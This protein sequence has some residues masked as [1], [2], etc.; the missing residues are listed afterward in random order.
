M[1]FR[2]RL[3]IGRACWPSL[4]SQ[5]CSPAVLAL[6]SVPVI[7]RAGTAPA[8]PAQDWLHVQG[9]KIVDEAG[10]EVWLTGTN[11]F[12][13]NTSERVFHGLW[14]GNLQQITKSMA[15]RGIN[16]VRIP[17]SAQVLLEWSAGQTI[18]PNVNLFVNP[19]LTGLNNLQVFDR[20]LALCE[21]Y[22]TEGL[23]RP[24]QRRG[25]QCRSRLSPVV[26]GIH[27]HRA[28]L[29]GLVVGDQPVQDRTTRSSART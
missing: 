10:K 8:A 19:D 20:F 15:D 13:F 1:I 22:G 3:S 26:Q 21:Q 29:P 4:R 16:V 18:T 12:G 24:A 9:N 2:P 28:R 25:R 23:P 11:W 27:H 6:A 5:H 17:V 7:S 14:S